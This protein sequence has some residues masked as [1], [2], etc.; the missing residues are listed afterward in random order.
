M[1]NGERTLG[2]GNIR[3]L[4]RLH[5]FRFDV[6]LRALALGRLG[7]AARFTNLTRRVQVS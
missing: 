2:G 4:H 1:T 7:K 6:G 5:R 3:R